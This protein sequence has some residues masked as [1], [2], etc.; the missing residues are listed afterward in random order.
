M[1]AAILAFSPSL[2]GS[3]V[4]DDNE[5]IRDSAATAHLLPLTRFFAGDFWADVASPRQSGYYRPVVLMSYAAQRAMSGLEPLPFHAF[6]LLGHAA[7]ALLVLL[8]A[9]SL[10]L[11]TLQSAL[12]AL[13]FAVHPAHTESVAWV[14][15]RT[16]VLATLFCLASLLCALPARRPAVNLLALPLF[17]LALLSKESVAL[18]PLLVLLSP[19]FGAFPR[20]L[21]AAVPFL[22]A[23]AAYGTL[24]L[25]AIGP[26]AA[27]TTGTLERLGGAGKTLLAYVPRVLWPTRL[28][29][30]FEVAPASAMALPLAALLASLLVLGACFAWRGSV[31]GTGLAIFVLGL[32]PTLGIVPIHDASAF[33]FLY[34]PLLGLL[35]LLVPTGTWLAARLPAPVAWGSTIVVLVA[36]GGLSMARSRDF[37]SDEA[38]FA[39]ER[40]LSPT[41]ARMALNMGE[42][43]RRAGKLEEAARYYDELRATGPDTIEVE[44]AWMRSLREAGHL[45]RAAAA[46]KSVI[47]RHPD[48]GRARI[49]MG[50]TLIAQGYPALAQ[51]QLEKA[52]AL[53]PEA[54]LPRVNLALL[55]VQRGRTDDALTVLEPALERQPHDV[56]LL[57]AQA[58]ALRR[59]ARYKEALAIL[60]QLVERAPRRIELWLEMAETAFATGMYEI[61]RGADVS[62]LA[63]DDASVR[64]LSN[65]ALVEL[66][67]GNIEQATALLTRAVRAA[68][69]SIDL[70]LNLASCQAQ[71]GKLDDAAATVAEARR[72]WPEDARA[73]AIDAQLERVRAAAPAAP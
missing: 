7:T 3:F 9:R 41:S 23:G 47:D 48:D 52:V 2:R 51:E 38:L 55:M 4:W 13:G 15:G 69:D 68:P 39:A 14:S 66:A 11:S 5:L 65:L 59:L 64:A 37:R 17:L 25:R 34:L 26:P 54:P 20:R 67:E 57:Y 32:L 29:V 28:P 33:R 16:D 21:L 45:D 70:R 1:A 53:M 46:G 62:A 18:M 73:R 31:A 19:T 43:L 8:L 61:A 22:A 44:T 42:T 72:L 36:L 24:R 30:D 60:E 35:L 12:V 6:N 71:L 40:R 50:L 56:E 58:T 10:G 27:A 63:I 49:E